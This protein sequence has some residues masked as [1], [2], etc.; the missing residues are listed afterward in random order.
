MLLLLENLPERGLRGSHTQGSDMRGSG[1]SIHFPWAR[2]PRLT[3]SG[4]TPA[5]ATLWATGQVS[6]TSDEAGLGA[7][8]AFPFGMQRT[9]W[10]LFALRPLPAEFP[11]TAEGSRSLLDT[12]PGEIHNRPHWPVPLS[13]QG[14]SMRGS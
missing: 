14:C 12:A 8:S 7:E 5:T 1:P 10:P 4:C 9:D 2:H 6:G 13:P 11:K 3:P